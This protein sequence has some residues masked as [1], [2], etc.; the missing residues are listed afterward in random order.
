MFSL[1]LSAYP[2]VVSEGL[3]LVLGLHGLCGHHGQ[4]GGGE[5]GG[6]QPISGVVDPVGVSPFLI[7]LSAVEQ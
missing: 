6:G 2:E 1:T 7:L 4:C 5:G 3:G